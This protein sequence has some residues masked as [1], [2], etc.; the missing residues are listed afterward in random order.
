MAKTHRAA[1]KI[2]LVVRTA[3]R[4]RPR[5][6]LEDVLLDRCPV[7]A[8]DADDAAHSAVRPRAGRD[9]PKRRSLVNAPVWVENGVERITHG[10]KAGHP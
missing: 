10:V 9:Q 8:S 1:D 2:T 7:E 3:V 5:H 4:E 6:G